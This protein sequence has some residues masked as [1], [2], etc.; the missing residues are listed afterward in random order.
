MKNLNFGDVITGDCIRSIRPGFGLDP[1]LKGLV[2]GRKVKASV[3]VG[4]RV[5]MDL[6]EIEND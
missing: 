4:D 2:I 3:S 5:S 6:I 1:N